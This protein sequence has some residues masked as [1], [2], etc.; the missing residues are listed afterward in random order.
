ML[1]FPGQSNL[2]MAKQ[3]GAKH[4]MGIRGLLVLLICMFYPSVD[5]A[6]TAP[7]SALGTQGNR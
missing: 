6:T 1:F 3:K 2:P 5:S 7:V 4:T